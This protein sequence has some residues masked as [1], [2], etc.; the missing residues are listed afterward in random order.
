MLWFPVRNRQ[1]RRPDAKGFTMLTAIDRLSRLFVSPAFLRCYDLPSVQRRME[2]KTLAPFG[3]EERDNALRYARA[4][5]PT[6]PT[7]KAERV[8]P[9]KATCTCGTSLAAERDTLITQE[10]FPQIDV[11]K[12]VNTFSCYHG[13][14]LPVYHG[15]LRYK[16]APGVAPTEHFAETP[17]DK[18]E[19]CAAERKAKK[20]GRA[21]TVN[22]SHTCYAD[23]GRKSLDSKGEYRPTGAATCE[24]LFTQGE[25][26]EDGFSRT[27]A[28]RYLQKRMVFSPKS[29]AKGKEKAT[30]SLKR[31]RTSS[32]K[33]ATSF[34]NA[35]DIED[36]IQEAAAFYRLTVLI[37]KGK[38]SWTESEA[39]VIDA[40][41]KEERNTVE[42]LARAQDGNR[43]HDTTSACQQ[44]RQ[45]M[46]RKRYNERKR[47]AEFGPDG[48][49]TTYGLM[50]MVRAHRQET[51]ERSRANR[52]YDA[53]LDSLL[54]AVQVHG[55]ES[56]KLLAVVLDISAGELCKRLAR[57][58]ERCEREERELSAD[59]TRFAHG[60]A[61]HGA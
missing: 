13:E 55:Y 30:V 54:A 49:R 2:R 39:A 52:F 38:D 33:H 8:C 57:L 51:M 45:L 56:Q 40:L 9:C 31:G 58:R 29:N 36:T 6:V 15:I 1:Q 60:Y 22:I 42:R 10:V 14:S 41:P 20:E 43:L 59:R 11:A 12:H 5:F 17:E 44:A 26:E 32:A 25:K 24:A 23:N 18:C 16:V 28:L 34:Y 21:C 19:R 47:V 61:M 37:K 7:F 53:E 48:K 35:S 50:A 46:M 4:G 3:R 27:I